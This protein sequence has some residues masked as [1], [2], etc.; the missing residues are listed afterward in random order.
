MKL[1]V[2]CWIVL[3]LGSMGVAAQTF[4]V[5]AELWLAPRSGQAMRDNTQMSKA[6]AAYFQLAQ[7]RVRLHHH[8]RDE[9]S[10]H[11]EELR[12]WLIALGIEASRIEL[13]EDSPTDQLTLDIT[14]NR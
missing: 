12:G 8:K 11:A 1:K 6:F 7:P 9:S 2:L 14:D 10:A 3:A 4:E 13:V 5:P